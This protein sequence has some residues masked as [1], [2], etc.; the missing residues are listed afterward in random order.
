M[1]PESHNDDTNLFDL[2]IGIDI[3]NKIHGSAEL[4]TFDV[5]EIIPAASTLCSD[6]L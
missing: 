1:A 6:A 2:Y 3:I 4:L 5:C